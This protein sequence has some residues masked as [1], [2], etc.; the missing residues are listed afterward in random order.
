MGS[1]SQSDPTPVV[2]ILNAS[3]DIKLREKRAKILNRAGFYTSSAKSAEEVIYLAAWLRCP[4]VIVCHSFKHAERRR[5]YDRV[6]ETAPG[7]AVVLLNDYADSD[8]GILI[9]TVKKAL[10]PPF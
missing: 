5:I 8:P 10:Q 4:I 6:R 2:L 3:R 9:D 1:I 7:T